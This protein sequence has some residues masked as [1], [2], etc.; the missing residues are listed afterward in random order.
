MRQVLRLLVVGLM[1]AGYSSCQTYYFANEEFNQAFQRGDLAFCE[2]WLQKHKP[3][4]RS[5]A[6]YLYYANSGMVK[7]IQGK[8]DSSNF[9]FEKA[10]L[11][12]EDYQRK[13]GEQVAAYLTNPKR[14]TYSGERHE[15]LLLHYF[16]ALNHLKHQ[17]TEESLIEA[18]RLVRKLNV[19]E[20]QGKGDRYSKDG[21]ML[22]VVGMIFENAGE[23]NN[24][25]IYYRKSIEAYEGEFGKINQLPVPD[26]LRE[27]VLRVAF[28]AGY[29]AEL[30]HF[31]QKFGRK[32]NKAVGAGMG[33]ALVF[34][35]R[36]MGPV[37]GESRVVFQ[38]VKGGGG[39]LVFTNEEWGFSFPFFWPADQAN[40][41]ARIDDIKVITMALPRYVNRHQRQTNIRAS[42]DGKKLDFQ[43]A[44]QIERI[45]QADLK[46]RM[47]RELGKALARLAVKQAVQYAATK[48]TESSIKGDGKSEKKNSQAEVAGSLVNLALTIANAATENADTRNWQT[49]P[50]SL[51]VLRLELPP[52]QHTL[53]WGS[54]M[55][56]TSNKKTLD[57]KSGQTSVYSL[58]AF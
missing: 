50:A 37:K 57:I 4:K 14:I 30:A 58:H 26:Q 1:C 8:A 40:R 18:R 43:E 24:A 33:T 6:K 47:N 45:A 51:S 55:G 56:G 19:W 53:E 42:L 17:K 21:F 15:Q 35:H 52:G 7:F 25:F 13:A 54:G 16:K 34:L 49:L 32:W 10:F 39:Q 2:K 12:S 31:E 5:K 22:W 20:D 48:A 29:D 46:D 3:R 23:V 28:Q 9:V 38:A 41:S 11:L 27:D 36:G 44:S